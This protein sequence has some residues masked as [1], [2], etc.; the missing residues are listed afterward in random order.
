MSQINKNVTYTKA[1][2]I[3]LMVAAHS[4]DFLEYFNKPISMF[5]MPLFFIMSGFCLKDL[6]F[7]NPYSF[8][9]R[10]MKTLWWVYV[11]YS[12]IF[13]LIHN[14]FCSLYLLDSRYWSQYPYTKEQIVREIMGVFV[15]MENHELLLGQFWFVKSLFIASLIVF[16]FLYIV[17]RVEVFYNMSFRQKTICFSVLLMGGTIFTMFLNYWHWTFDFF[18]ISPREFLSANFILLGYGINKFKI[19]CFSTVQIVFSF[20]FLLLTT[21][22][23]FF[24]FMKDDFHVTIRIIPFIITAVLITWSIYSL[25]WSFLHGICSKVLLFIG[26][27][28]LSILVWHVL[29]FK[30]VSLLIVL[31]YGLPFYELG[32][33]HVIYRYADQ[34][35]LIMYT[36]VG[37]FMPLLIKCFLSKATETFNVMINKYL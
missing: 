28:T 26:N 10:K 19:G 32:E 3:I 12:I 15:H 20:L 11:K 25:P 4:N 27:N 2:G 18:Q 37:V 31:L 7:D 16:L 9:R 36:L 35:W 34:G 6:Y 24:G 5:H 1:V 23:C 13:I 22:F 29:S 8:I 33:Y 30:V 17:K 14:I 21:Q